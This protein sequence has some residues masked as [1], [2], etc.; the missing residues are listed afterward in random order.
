MHSPLCVAV[1]PSSSLDLL[2]R[3]VSM[4]LQNYPGMYSAI[5]NVNSVHNMVFESGSPRPLTWRVRNIAAVTRI[6]CS[7]Y[8]RKYCD[9]RSTGCEAAVEGLIVRRICTDRVML[10]ARHSNKSHSMHAALIRAHPNTAPFEYARA[11]FVSA[12]PSSLPS[13]ARAVLAR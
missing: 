8:W 13:L 11:R 5:G 3:F 4:S 9:S 1:F 10:D 12:N 2:S 7:S 6:T